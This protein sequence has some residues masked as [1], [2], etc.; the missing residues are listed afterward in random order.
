MEVLK[1]EFHQDNNQESSYEVIHTKILEFSCKKIIPIKRIG[2]LLTRRS[3]TQKYWIFLTRKSSKQ[4]G[5]RVFLREDHPHKNIL[6]FPYEKIIQSYREFFSM[7]E[8]NWHVSRKHQDKH[9][10]IFECTRQSW[11]LCQRKPNMLQGHQVTAG[12]WKMS[13]TIEQGFKG[14][15]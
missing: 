15:K 1:K 7:K 5:P 6:E 2:S 11:N 13:T 12:L 9:S 3:S 4:T 8:S 10:T 14:A